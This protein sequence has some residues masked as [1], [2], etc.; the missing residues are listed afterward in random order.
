M[1]FEVFTTTFLLVFTVLTMN[2]QINESVIKVRGE[3]VMRTVPEILDIN[4]PIQEKAETY[5]ACTNKLTA[6]FNDL[7]AAL[8]KSGIAKEKIYS[9][10]L[11]IQ[12][13]Y[14]YQD[15]KRVLIGYIG[16]IALTMEL[17]HTSENLNRVMQTLNNEKFNFGYQAS[18]SLSE[19]QKARLRE[20]AIKEAVADAKNKAAILAEAL[21]V[22]LLE[23][24][25]VNFEFSDGGDDILVVQRNYM[26]SEAKM[27][28]GSNDIELNPEEQEI[29]KSVGIIWWIGN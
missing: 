27:D 28:S 6:T 7:N 8:V 14:E 1:K 2:A 23:I 17:A 15:R 11:S 22:K 29:R 13:D 25:E 19:M 3:A 21:E 24:K 9:N 5:E 20:A 26:M 18:F 16:S 12:E 4:I 10:R